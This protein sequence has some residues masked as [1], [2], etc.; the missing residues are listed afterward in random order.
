[1]ENGSVEYVILGIGVNVYPPEDGF[2][3]EIRE[4]AGAVFEGKQHDGKNRLAA[5]I[6][7]HFLKEYRK[8]DRTDYVEKYRAKSF[9]VGK[10]ITILSPSGNRQ[11]TALDVD[12]DCHLIVR[13]ENGQTERLS[14]GEISI[15]I[16]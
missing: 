16:S 1:M 6:L 15:R 2:P 5:G 7:N 9:V 4:T 12:Q 3:E 11:A 14:S 8:T 13:Y 10:E